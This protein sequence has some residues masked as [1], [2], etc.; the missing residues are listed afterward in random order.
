MSNVKGE[1]DVTSTESGT[2]GMVGNNPRGSWAIPETFDS[3]EVERLTRMDHC[4]PHEARS[5]GHLGWSWG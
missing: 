1:S 4:G 2:T 5:N 3:L